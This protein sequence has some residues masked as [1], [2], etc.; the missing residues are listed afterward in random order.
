MFAVTVGGESSAET[1]PGL[2][3]GDYIKHSGSHD[4]AD[5]LRDDVG[6][7]VGALEAIAR[8]QSDRDRRIDVAA[9]DAADS[10]DHRQKGQAKGNRHPGKSDAELRK[11]RGQ[12][13][14]TASA[15]HQPK[16]AEK[17]GRQ[18]SFQTDHRIS[19]S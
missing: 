19:S 3:A 18:P 16:G 13:R 11:G 10:V 14:A 17:L 9:G 7:D 2:S 15:E 12:H 1:E 6:N 5:Y 4:S 8:P